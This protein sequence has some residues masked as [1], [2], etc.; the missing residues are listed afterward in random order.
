M[1]GGAGGAPE[2]IGRYRVDDVIGAGAFATAYRAIDERLEATVVLKVLAENHSLNPDVRERF[3]AEG[4]SLRKV[5][6]SHVV[7][8]YDIGE[9]DRQQPYLVLEY[10]NRGTLAERVKHLRA[11]G[12]TASAA[13]V[14]SLAQALAHALEDLHAARIVHRDLSPSNVLLTADPVEGDR[15]GADDGRPP[16]LIAP[17]ERV[18]LADL[19]MCKD[20]A[21]NSGLTV[22][23]GTSGFRPPEMELGPAVID[24]RADLWSVSALMRWLTAG[25]DLPPELGRVLDRSLSLEPGDRHQDVGQWLADVEAALSPPAPDVPA[26]GHDVKQQHPVGSARPDPALVKRPLAW[27]VVVG[28]LVSGALTGWL[29]RGGSPPAGSG[30]SQIAV[31]GPERTPTGVAATFT[32]E[33]EGVQSWV[34]ELPDGTYVTDQGAVTLT[35]SG[36]GRAT[37]VVRAQAQD[38][39]DLYTEHS[40][41]V[42][43]R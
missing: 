15:R 1:T 29:A 24:T 40:W 9:S 23:G 13:D 3:I 38:G 25:A 5:Q 16:S 14:R 17:D 26:G 41:D 21:L 10:A 42:S 34:W 43:D 11:E 28:L 31:E 30:P 19:G 37:L 12:W 22:A 7:I 4:R 39:T 18:L 33:R 27:L 36:P 32:L 6:S 20:L 35:P 2:R 8:V